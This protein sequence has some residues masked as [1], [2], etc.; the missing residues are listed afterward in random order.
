MLTVLTAVTLFRLTQLLADESAITF[1]K[2]TITSLQ[3]AALLLLELS[4]LS[5]SIPSIAVISRTHV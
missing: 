3:K 5:L 1:I 2:D 4:T